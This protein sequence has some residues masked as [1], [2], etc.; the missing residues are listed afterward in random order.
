MKWPHRRC[1]VK[2]SAAHRKLKNTV[3]LALE[4]LEDRRVPA[5]FNV[6]T[7]AGLYQAVAS[8]NSLGQTASSTINIA[9]GNVHPERWHPVCERQYHVPWHRLRSRQDDH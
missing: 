1:R 3:R 6:H 7:I 2:Q 4:K 8:A 9:A 5:T